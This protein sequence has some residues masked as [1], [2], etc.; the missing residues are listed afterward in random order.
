MSWSIWNSTGRANILRYSATAASIRTC[1]GLELHTSNATHAAAL[2]AR[3]HAGHK[4]AIST[5]RIAS[6]SSCASMKVAFGWFFPCVTPSP[7]CG[8]PVF[9]PTGVY[10][11]GRWGVFAYLY[12]KLE[13]LLLI[14]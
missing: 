3:T 6:Y 5:S 14:S 8:L 13:E 9:D 10:G 2:A 7:L 1:P 11:Q 4:H 12:D